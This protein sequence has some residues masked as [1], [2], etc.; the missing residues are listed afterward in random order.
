MNTCNIYR[1]DDTFCAKSKSNSYRYS[2]IVSVLILLLPFL[3]YY[4]LP[5]TSIGFS[6][7]LFFI[8]LIF[9]I[10][11]AFGTKKPRK[12]KSAN[13]KSRF[14]WG[15]FLLWTTF[16]TAL[17][18][19]NNKSAN[20][21]AATNT[22]VIMAAVGL[23]LFL[24][25]SNSF[26]LKPFL[27]IYDFFISICIIV[28]AIQ[29]LL[30]ASGIIISFQ[31]PFLNYNDSWEGLKTNIFGMTP[32]PCSLFSEKSHL[33]NFILPYL[34]LRLFARI[35]T[36]NL[37]TNPIVL[38]FV[39]LSTI[40]GNGIIGSLIVWLLFFLFFGKI[41]GFKRIM[42]ICSGAA[43]LVL[44][45]FVLLKIEVFSDMFSELFVDNSGS[46][47]HHT[48]ADYRIYR[49][50]DIFGMLP[51]VNKFIGVGYNQAEVFSKAHGIVSIYDQDTLAYEY[52]SMISAI[53]IYTGLFGL[54]FYLLHLWYLFKGGNKVTKGLVVLFVAIMFSTSMLFLETQII[55]TLM[56]AY[57]TKMVASSE[58]AKSYE[59]CWGYYN[60][61]RC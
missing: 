8:I 6:S 18:Y 24:T 17:F 35:K 27:Q 39:L 45:Y 58:K 49:G 40:S 36:K 55:Y 43:L 10:L 60:T 54:F 13:S 11:I 9:L 57:S 37:L 46:A 5:F 4:D 12:N 2:F 41:K 20:F 52:F 42:V 53:I 34:A 15:I 32:L 21:L 14:W 3:R 29:W 22:I 38:S 25:L 1:Y 28:Y 26:E 56:I 33:C 50:F 47:Y 23:I 31:V 19:F 30:F 16:I 61:L 44:I 7:F 48:K 59:K 51:T